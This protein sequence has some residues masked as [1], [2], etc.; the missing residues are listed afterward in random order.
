MV[1]LDTPNTLMMGAALVALIDGSQHPFSQIL[2][3][4]F[5]WLPPFGARLL[6]VSPFIL[7]LGSRFLPT[8]VSLL[9]VKF[10]QKRD[11][12]ERVLHVFW[13]SL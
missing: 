11:P 13:A 3:I 9:G 8:A 4:G 10:S 12:R 6:L 2:R 5:H 1:A 7:S